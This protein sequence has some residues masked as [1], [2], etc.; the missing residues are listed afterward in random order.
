MQRG[1]RE[2]PIGGQP[3]SPHSP[4]VFTWRPEEKGGCE[5]EIKGGKYEGKGVYTSANGIQYDGELKDGK[6]NSPGTLTRPDGQVIRGT[7]NNGC[8]RQGNRWWAVMVTTKACG[9]Q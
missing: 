6:A 1:S 9:F 3:V 8:Y 5:G 2:S 7:W 4:C